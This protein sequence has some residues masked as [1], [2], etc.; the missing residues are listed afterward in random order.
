LIFFIFLLGELR[1][2]QDLERSDP[3]AF[4]ALLERNG[5]KYDPNYIRGGW[6]D[7]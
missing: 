5:I 7:Q 6:N 1:Y 3:K 4:K 2:Q